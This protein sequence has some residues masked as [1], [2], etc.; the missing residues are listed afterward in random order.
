MG[1][2]KIK[3]P[4]IR[5]GI[6]EENSDRNNPSP[7]SG[8]L[9]LRLETSRLVLLSRAKRMPVFAALFLRKTPFYSLLCSQVFQNEIIILTSVH[10]LPDSGIDFMVKRL[11]LLYVMK[12]KSVQLA[13]MPSLSPDSYVFAPTAYASGIGKCNATEADNGSG[14]IVILHYPHRGSCKTAGSK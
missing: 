1:E 3:N 2:R 5:R 4:S 13:R 14:K 8:G 6:E 9:N 12:N 10:L 7:R 11:R